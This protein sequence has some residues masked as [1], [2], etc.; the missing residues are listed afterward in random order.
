MFMTILIAAFF[1]FAAWVFLGVLWEI[2]KDVF[3]ELFVWMGDEELIK[4]RKEEKEREIME[5]THF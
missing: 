3:T 2:V 4:K 5:N 1:L